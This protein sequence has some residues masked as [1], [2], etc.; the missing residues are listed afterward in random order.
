MQMTRYKCHNDCKIIFENDTGICPICETNTAVRE[1]CPRDHCHCSH[2]VVET[3]TYCPD[4]KEPMCPTCEC[5]DV[6]QISR[7]TGYL[8]EVGGWNKGKAQ[9]LKDRT[10]AKP[11]E[12]L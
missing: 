5:H 1:M 3:I 12:I 10:R 7:V 11:E 8:Q 2:E 6:V 9:E 4:C